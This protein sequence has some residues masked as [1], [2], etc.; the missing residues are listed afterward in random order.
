MYDSTI[1]MLVYV[2]IS[3]FGQ[4][5]FVLTMRE[6]RRPDFSSISA[7]IHCGDRELVLGG[8]SGN[9]P[10]FST[11]SIKLDGRGS[12][13]PLDVQEF[14]LAERATYRVSA[15]CLHADPAFQIRVYRAAR[16]PDGHVTYDIRTL[17]VRVNG[18]IIDRGNETSTADAFWFR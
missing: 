14:L 10:G 1:A 5:E 11:P 13:V 16:L 18:T 2:A 3:P 6:P 15:S 8:V 7:E 4:N 17:E 9:G 12:D